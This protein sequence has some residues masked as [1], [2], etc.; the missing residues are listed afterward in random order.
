MEF[1]EKEVQKLD[2]MVLLEDFLREAK[3]LWIIG[4][5]LVVVLGAYR[6]IQA[7][8]S[9]SPVYQASA[10][11]TVK[12][13][14]PLYADVSTYN[15]KTAEQM[16]KT[17]PHILNSGLL[18]NKVKEALGIPYMPSVSVSVLPNS[19]VITL[20]VTDSDPQRAYDVLNGVIAYYPEIAE[21]VVGATVLQLLD[22]SGVPTGP[23]NY[24]DVRNTVIKGVMLG[25][26][27]WLLLVLLFAMTKNTIHNAE[28]LSKLLNFDCFGHVPS[29]K[30]PGRDACPL[31]H[32]GRRKPD[33]SEAFRA[34]RLRVERAMEQGDKKVLL[35][36]SAI[37]G[38]GKTTI[39][40]NLAIALA[41]R[42]KRVLLIDCDLRSP[43]VAKALRLKTKHSLVDFL[44]GKMM[45]RELLCP[46]ETENLF[47]IPGGP[48][49]GKVTD[50]ITRER[51][52]SMIQAARKLFDFVIL[53]T[54]PCSLLAD[55]A[56][57]AALADA[58]LLVVRQ[59]Y[60]SRDQIID[61]VQRLTDAELPIIG[62]VFN[63]VE[64]A[65][66]SGSEYGYGAAYGYGRKG[67]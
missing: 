12:V 57:V 38:E 36:S 7:K 56:E 65:L 40:V 11:F 66:P 34:A 6:G 67:R 33:F 55:A 63:Y 59:D 41:R 1:D 60:A 45:L 39:S 14:D 31:L 3:R 58:G 47:V 18:E 24:L 19:S 22:E 4:L 61:G 51:G 26:G 13:A 54:P 52:S 28:M 49:G 35:I 37:P 53:D 29:V 2:L 62:W 27:C 16:A 48:G 23:I 50:L 46:T 43:S 15:M 32:V 64:R 10:T 21:F 5:V 30:V 20:R 25:A 42:G 44:T 9:Y 17:F 8:R